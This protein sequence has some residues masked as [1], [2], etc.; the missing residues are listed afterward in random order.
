[1]SNVRELVTLDVSSGTCGTAGGPHNF[2]CGLLR[3]GWARFGM[4]RYGKV[5]WCVAR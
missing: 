5:G 3:L 1:M 4:V 2:W